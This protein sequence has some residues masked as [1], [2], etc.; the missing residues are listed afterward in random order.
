MAPT[1]KIAATLPVAVLMFAAYF[2]ADTDTAEGADT[3][4]RAPTAEA[5]PGE[6][7][8]AISALQSDNVYAV[9]NGNDNL[10]TGDCQGYTIFAF[11]VP[12]GNV[13][14]GIEVR[15][16]GYCVCGQFLVE[17]SGD[18]GAT[19]TPSKALSPPTETF[20]TL[21]GPT[22]L[23]GY[24]WS[25]SAINRLNL[26]FRIQPNVLGNASAFVDH[27]LVK[28]YHHTDADGD[29]Y[30]PPADCN[31]SDA[32]I[33]PGATEADNRVD[34]DCDGFIDE[35]FITLCNLGPGTACAWG[36][37]SS[38]QLGNGADGDWTSP[39]QIE[40]LYG[41]V[42]LAGGDEHSLALLSDG[43]VMAWGDDSDGQ[44]GN[45]LAT[46]DQ[47]TP[48][49]VV[50]GLG[51]PVLTNVVAIA[52]AYTHSLALLG[53]GSV[54][55]WGLVGFSAQHFPTPVTGI[56]SAVGIAA[57]TN[58]DLAVLANGTVKAWG[59]NTW[60]QLGNG[61]T[62]ASATPVTV[63]N[64]TNAVAVAAGFEHS[65]ALL[66]DGT[67]RAWGADSL[68]QLGNTALGPDSCA[69]SGDGRAC[70][71]EPVTIEGLTNAVAVSSGSV[72]DFSV[73]L[74][75]DGTVKSWGDFPVNSNLP[76]SVG[77]FTGPVVAVATGFF[78]AI[79]LL[80]D[81]TMMAWGS[82]EAGQLGNGA[83][84][85]RGPVVVSGLRGVAVIGAGAA[86]SMAAGGCNGLVATLTGTPNADVITGTD[87]DDVILG[88]GGSDAIDAGEG[89]DTICAGDGNDSISG[90]GGTDSISGGMGDDFLG[91]GPG[92][93]TAHFPAASTTV[94][95]TQGTAFSSVEGVDTLSSIENARGSNEADTLIGNSNKNKL[96]GMGG[97]DTLRGL[98]SADTL[99]GSTGSDVLEGGPGTDT[100][101][102]GP[103]TDT[104]S[105]PGNVALTINLFSGKN[106]MGD[107]L[108]S[109][110]SVKGSNAN[111]TI[112]GSATKNR[113][114]G[115][116]GNDTINGGNGSD[117]LGG[118][119]G[120]ADSCNGGPGNDVFVGGSKAASGCETV[121]SI[122]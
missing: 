97:S 121:V 72:S 118:G 86:H 11:N 45:G 93:D 71:T 4:F 10:V 111:D 90:G 41:V 75:N 30:E 100:L 107:A 55:M 70:S 67:G 96:E 63:S 9:G 102:G 36:L 106:N 116:G 34:D 38:G 49:Q 37:D 6:W 108:S 84:S 39:D 47:Q 60:G 23:W 68:G 88:L 52:A 7:A 115:M 94:N 82:D 61:T 35:G 51:T 48:V 27:V 119:P 113:L 69:L 91:G 120:P 114:E 44:L 76:V 13:I 78:H 31:D 25:S 29:G 8:S 19:L 101:D 80:T 58:H 110:E 54:V 24:A 21:G 105:Y 32:S 59:D 12:N 81:G 22:D 2:V 28:V 40:G 18:G 122:P 89:E 53:D 16:E 42:A 77:G 95:L 15:V 73:A 109:V 112:T 33:N 50:G 56:T 46:G 92:S 64:I 1:L 3:G 104:A 79:A 62:T 65:I 117:T 74:L 85:G 57:G 103:Q 66:A 98:L 43:T 5:S 20:T 87:Q 26:Y 17:L 14:D 83:G 99:I